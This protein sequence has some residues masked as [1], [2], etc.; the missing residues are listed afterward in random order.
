MDVRSCK[1]DGVVCRFLQEQEP[2][3][4][5]QMRKKKVDDSTGG[6][7]GRAHTRRKLGFYFVSDTKPSEGS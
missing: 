3:C 4:G 2:H 7:K 6:W 5:N 1:N